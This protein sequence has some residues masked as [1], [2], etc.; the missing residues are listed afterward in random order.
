VNQNKPMNLLVI[1]DNQGDF[2][3]LNEYLRASDLA[4][5][6]NIYHASMI[7]EVNGLA[8]DKVIDVV[9]LDLTLP[10][11]E[12]IESFQKVA[13]LLPRTPIIV[14]SGMSDMDVALEAIVKGAQDYLIKGEFEEKLLSKTIQYSIERKR[15]LDDLQATKERYQ[16]ANKATNDVI[17]KY[18]FE[19]D[20]VSWGEGFFEVF[21][22]DVN[23]LSA[24]PE[25]SFANIH[26]DDR[27]R[28]RKGIEALL[29]CG[30]QNWEAEYMFRCADGSYKSIYNR[31]F[32]LYEHGKPNRMFG[33]ITDLTEK[34]ELEK[35]LMEQQLNQ[36][37]LMTEIAIQAQEAERNEL[38][39]ELHD[40][41][42]QLLAS[43]KMS[44]S[45]AQSQDPVSPELIDQ[46]YKYIKLAM[47]EVRKLSHTLIAPSLGDISLQEALS[48]LIR[49]INTT[50]SF[51]VKLE[52]DLDANAE[53][54]D[55]KKLCLYRI[56][57]EQMNNIRKHA[58][59]TSVVVILSVS[60]DDV[61]LSVEDNGRGFDARGKV[62]GIGLRNIQN[63]VRFM[64]GDFTLVTAPGEGCTIKVCIPL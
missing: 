61:C 35:E 31:G 8:N 44:L 63:R 12:G 57:Q 48:G 28:V 23:G 32:V 38:G 62:N 47:S 49:E 2:F 24:S 26:V 21:G 18:E 52:T 34:K 56:T 22:Y 40:N 11:S 25:F 1:E 36:Q 30:R 54:D 53:I 46:S 33:A 42:N 37:K 45:I 4:T 7:S 20:S 16:F 51:E 59:A 55:K 19:S 14:L 6:G 3:L 17:W 29:E 10:D 58:E 15:I 50:S 13:N 39:V 43:V 5:I 9:L 41:I 64:N 27:D 60:S